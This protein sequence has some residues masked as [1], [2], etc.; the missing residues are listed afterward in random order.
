MQYVNT[1]YPWD[2]V[3]NCKPGEIPERFNATGSYIRMVTIPEA[4]RKDAEIRL[5]FHGAE[6]A[7]ALWVNGTFVGYH[8]DSFTPA[9]FAIT[10]YLNDGEN[11]IAV[12]VF[13]RS[14]GSWLEDQDIWRFSGLFRDVVLYAVPK[15]HLQD[16]FVHT[17]Y[18]D[19]FSQ[20]DVRV[21]CAFSGTASGTLR[22]VLT[23][24]NGKPL[25]EL[26][27]PV[28]ASEQVVAFS[29][30]QP[31]LWSAEQPKFVS[32]GSDFAG[33]GWNGSGHCSET[34]RYSDIPYGKWHLDI[35]GKRIVS[36]GVNRA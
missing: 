27:I 30:E 21:D 19:T 14:S 15:L 20:A 10:D 33:C 26:S 12:Q 22:A 23:D 25:A 32:Y 6:T 18:N 17:D 3:E 11:K 1:M 4:F 34:N 9:E 2:G 36:N 24:P 8:E 7:M 35:D 28:T 13:Q 5:V 16:L 29:V 31:L